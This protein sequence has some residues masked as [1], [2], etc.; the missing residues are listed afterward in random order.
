MR[1]AVDLAFLHFGDFGRN[2]EV[3]DLLTAAIARTPVPAAVQR[4][5]LDLQSGSAGGQR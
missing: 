1:R 2:D 3:L 5:F 4:R